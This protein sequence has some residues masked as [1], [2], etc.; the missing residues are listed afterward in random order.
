M[1][2]TEQLA[3]LGQVADMA[4]KDAA[5]YEQYVPSL[6]ELASRPEKELQ[7]WLADFLLDALASVLALEKRRELALKAL[8]VVDKLLNGE[9]S[10]M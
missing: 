3:S 4:A 5:L 8:T 2:L 6:L 7:Q 1:S 9:V 10:T